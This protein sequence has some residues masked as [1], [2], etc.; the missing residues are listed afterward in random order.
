MFWLFFSVGEGTLIV[1]F[2]FLFFSLKAA[3]DYDIECLEQ[4]L[5]RKREA[6]ALAKQK[7]ADWAQQLT[8]IENE[9]SRILQTPVKEAS[10]NV[11]VKKESSLSST[12]SSSPLSSS[13]MI[14]D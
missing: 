8:L 5:A 9:N 7:L 12:P 10:G 2:L 11:V 4:R 3:L 13:A 14:D 6:L 1:L